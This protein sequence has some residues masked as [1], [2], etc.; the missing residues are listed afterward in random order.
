MRLDVFAEMFGTHEAL[1]AN[2]MADE[3][4][5]TDVSAEVT[6]ELVGACESFTAEEPIAEKRTSASW[7]LGQSQV[8]PP[9]VYC[10]DERD[11]GQSTTTLV[12]RS[13]T[14]R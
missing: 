8:A 12:V 13:A 2:G 6:L 9:R 14:L 10:R 3:A 1:V 11:D 5:L 4:L 7:Q